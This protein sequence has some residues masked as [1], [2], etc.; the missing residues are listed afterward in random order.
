MKL[1]SLTISAM[2]LTMVT[3]THA[4]VVSLDN[5]SGEYSGGVYI[6][7]QIPNP[8]AAKPNNNRLIAWD[9]I[10]G[11]TLTSDLNLDW[12][13]GSSTIDAGTTVSSHYIQ[14]DPSYRASVY[15]TASFDA[16]ILG[17]IYKDNSL[18]STDSLLGRAGIVYNDFRARGLEG[19]PFSGTLS[20]DYIANVTGQSFDFHFKATN[21]GDWVRV[22]TTGSVGA[23][24]SAIPEPSSYMMMLGGL[25]LISLMAKRRRKMG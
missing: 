17:F 19:N 4:A 16:D 24:V 7:D 1:F 20:K 6:N 21:P 12:G 3:S 9:E 5:I 10:Q 18:D 23:T 25:G 15:G 22:V 8:V 13:V 2:V 11:I 14:W